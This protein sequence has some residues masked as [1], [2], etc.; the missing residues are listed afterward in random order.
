[1][2]TPRFASSKRQQGFN[3]IGVAIAIVIGLVVSVGIFTVYA[4]ASANNRA[5]QSSNNMM[6]LKSSIQALYP[7]PQYTGLNNQL[8]LDAGKVPESM[9]GAAGQIKNVWASDIVV[10]TAGANDSLFTITTNNVPTDECTSMLGILASNFR[11]VEAGGQ[12]VKSPAQTFSATAAVA[13]CNNA[14]AGTTTVV[15]TD[16]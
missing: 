1:M 5:Q 16:G 8:L 11:Q 15:L 2:N 9:Q 10:T 3:L 4:S 14:G 13:G 6:L 7:S 12:T